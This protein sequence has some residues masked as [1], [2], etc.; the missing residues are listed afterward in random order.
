MSQENMKAITSM[1][2]GFE[3][4]K[5]LLN[6]K[7]KF[8]KDLAKIKVK[9]QIKIDSLIAFS[10]LTILSIM[11]FFKVKAK[12]KDKEKLFLIKELNKLKSEVVINIRNRNTGE[13]L[14]IPA[15]NKTII[16]EKIDA[17]LNKTDWSI[18]IKLYEDP[19]ITNNDIAKSI[20]LSV[21]GVRSS[22][23]K[24][25]SLF[26]IYEESNNNRRI[27]LVIEA[28]KISENKN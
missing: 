28:A 17:N 11:V 8:E 9:N 27:L 23:K 2:L 10:I 1:E 22:L 25:Y 12:Q 4:E 13:L 15:L 24:M 3:H 26:D 6:K 5:Q 21:A 18:L 16:E 14:N 20:H 19:G 7:I